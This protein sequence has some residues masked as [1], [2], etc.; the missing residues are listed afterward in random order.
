LSLKGATIFCELSGRTN[1]DITYEF[2]YSFIDFVCEKSD[3]EKKKLF[4]EYFTLT[5]EFMMEEC[6]NPTSEICIKSDLTAEAFVSII[7]KYKAEGVCKTLGVE[8]GETMKEGVDN[9][10]SSPLG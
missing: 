9:F 3:E 7:S 6:R 1:P 8:T 4:K 5:G 10:E 2:W